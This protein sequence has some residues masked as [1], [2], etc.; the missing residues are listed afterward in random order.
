MAFRCHYNLHCMNTSYLVIDHAYEKSSTK[1]TS[2]KIG[3][4][5][6]IITY[7]VLC[8]W[9]SEAASVRTRSDRA[10]NKAYLL[11]PT[12]RCPRAEGHLV[13]P[14]RPS[15]QFCFLRRSTHWSWMCFGRIEGCFEYLGGCLP[16]LLR[17]TDSSVTNERNVRIAAALT[18]FTDTMRTHARTHTHTHTHRY[19]YE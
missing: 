15:L 11:T 5:R 3:R 14:L 19:K 7:R 16:H 13:D 4:R 10:D 2:D 8:T 18:V 12:F 1:R 17:D 9:C 6:R